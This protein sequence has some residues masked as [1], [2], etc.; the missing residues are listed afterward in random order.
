MATAA[1]PMSSSSAAATATA[2]ATAA[3]PRSATKGDRVTVHL[4][5]TDPESK[6]VIADTVASSEPISFVVGQG[7][8]MVGMERRVLG[9]KAGDKWSDVFA[10]ADAFGPYRQE[11]VVDVPRK[12]GDEVQAQV[13]DVVQLGQGRLGRILAIDAD[14][15][16][17]DLNHPLAGRSVRL[18]VELISVDDVPKSEGGLHVERLKAGDGKTFPQRGAR[19]SVHYTGMLAENGKEFDSSRKRGKPF[20][21][22]LGAGM[23]I[24]GWEMGIAQLSL[25]ERAN[26][27]IPAALGYGDQAMGP[28]P[29]NSNLVF[30]VELVGVDG[31][32][33]SSPASSPSS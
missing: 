32:S 7:R 23:V 33:G 1:R 21:F 24:Q 30:D 11:D 26:L 6:E 22:V 2:T 15:I 29:P 31:P 12:A 16:K 8:V 28:I 9:M 3:T 14:K 18:D 10:P 27:Y 17:V 4:T 20:T 19:V 25:G 5:I 13:G